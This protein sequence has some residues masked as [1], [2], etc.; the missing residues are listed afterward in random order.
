[1]KAKEELKHVI[2]AS[3]P[4]E[5][6][7]S[8]VQE[9]LVSARTNN[10]KNDITGALLFGDN[11]YLQLLEGPVEPVTETVKIITDD[12]RHHE[13]QILKE[14][15][16]NR[17]LFASWTMRED[18]LATWSWT[19]EDIKNGLI[20]KLKPEEALNVFVNLSREIDQFI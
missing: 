1:M 7:M 17:R 9:I 6:D 3:R 13:I 16:T 4:T 18:S 12:P 19:S 11:L 10:E 2:Y 20:H 14:G 8:T 15:F 5:F